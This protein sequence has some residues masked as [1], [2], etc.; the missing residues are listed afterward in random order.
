MALSV[1]VPGVEAVLGGAEETI[2]FVAAV[3]GEAV[4]AE[5]VVEVVVA[6]VLGEAGVAGASLVEAGVARASLGEAVVA[7]ASLGEVDVH[8]CSTNEAMGEELVS[9]VF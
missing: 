6:A 2:G 3:L 5:E 4:V 1:P 8:C 9:W 7:G